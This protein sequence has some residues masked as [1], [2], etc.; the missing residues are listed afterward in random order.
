METLRQFL[1]DTLLINTDKYEVSVILLFTL[2]T[3]FWIYTYVKTLIN[4]RK[5]KLVEIPALVAAL[6]VSWEFCWGFLIVNDYGPIFKWASI[7]WFFMDVFINL[8]I[9]K[10]GR[11]LV[12]IPFLKANYTQIHILF[13]IAGGCITYSMHK[14]GLDDGIGIN[15]AYF[16]SIL[17]SGS[18]IY[19]L[20]NFP[21]LRDRGFDKSIAWS[22]LMG[23][24][25]V[26]IGCFI[27]YPGNYFLWTMCSLVFVMDAFYLYLFYSL[28]RKKVIVPVSFLKNYI[29]YPIEKLIKFLNNTID[30]IEG[31][32]EETLN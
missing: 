12:T 8:R 30:K 16:I 32:T 19:Q 21:E 13:L 27:H 10:Y 31:I 22:K 5:H 20:L 3:L 17:I 28:E 29:I 14:T 26:S 4:I 25:P 23:T 1:H 6:N 11:K 7:I 9:F 15:S 2:G 24:F 18:Y